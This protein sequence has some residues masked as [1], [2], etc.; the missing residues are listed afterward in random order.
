MD[1]IMTPQSPSKYAPWDLTQFFQSPSAA[2]SYFPESHGESETSSLAKEIL[3]LRK[4]EITGNQI[5]ALE[6]LSQ[7]GDLMFCKK[8]A[9]DVMH[10]QAPCCDE[11]AN[12]QLPIA[13]AF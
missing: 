6:G 9:Q 8:T 7:V 1:R 13:A 4:V 2:P 11:A 12:H 10:L 5:W 3:V